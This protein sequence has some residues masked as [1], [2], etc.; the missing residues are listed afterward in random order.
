MNSWLCLAT[1]RHFLAK[2]RATQMR[3]L[4]DAMEDNP[5]LKQPMIRAVV[6]A[7]NELVAPLLRFRNFEQQLPY[8]S[9]TIANGADFGTDYFART[10]VAKSNILVNSPNEAGYFYQ[11]LD[12]TGARLNGSNRYTVTFPKEQTPPVKGFWSLTL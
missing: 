1:R 7:E 12:A 5:A 9:S 6:E 4:L 10:A 3:A 11:D 8:H 2:R